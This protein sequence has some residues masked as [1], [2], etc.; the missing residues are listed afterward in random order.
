MQLQWRSLEAIIETSPDGSLIFNKPPYEYENNLIPFDIL[1]GDSG[2]R[3]VLENGKSI[4][5]EKERWKHEI[6]EFNKKFGS[7]PYIMNK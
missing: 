7:L 4:T 3:L 6:K 5:I 2:M 1:S